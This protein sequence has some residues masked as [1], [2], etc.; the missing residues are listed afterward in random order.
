MRKRL[1]IAA[2]GAAA[3]MLGACGGD[4]GNS[5]AANNDVAANQTA[6]ASLTGL[7]GPWAGGLPAYPRASAVRDAP[8][9]REGCTAF[10][11]DTP[12]TGEQVINFYS[13]I[14][15]PVGFAD[16]LQSNRSAGFVRG[17]GGPRVSITVTGGDPN[18]VTMAVCED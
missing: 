12:D 5:A 13:A 11:F 2:V 15:E 8:G 18:T 14:L 6:T 4:A 9:A 16:P 3:M 17:V 7:D 10:Y 1:G